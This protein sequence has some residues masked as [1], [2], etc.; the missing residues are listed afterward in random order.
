L[1]VIHWDYIS[2]QVACHNT[3]QA[4]QQAEQAQLDAIPRLLDLGLSVAQIAKALNLSVETVRQFVAGN[5][6]S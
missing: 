3:E 5:E 1:R 6:R 2:S 4:R